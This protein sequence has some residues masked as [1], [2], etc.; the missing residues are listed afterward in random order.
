MNKNVFVLF[1]LALVACG[2]TAPVKE[3]A[4]SANNSVLELVGNWQNASPSGVENIELNLYNDGNYDLSHTKFWVSNIAH[5]QLEVGTFSTS[6]NNITF[7]PTQWSCNTHDPSYTSNFEL[8]NTNL[9][10]YVNLGYV[11]VFDPLPQVQDGMIYSTGCFNESDGGSNFNEM[12]LSN[13]L[14]CSLLNQ[15]CGNN[16]YCCPGMS[17]SSDSGLCF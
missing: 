15:Q 14:N 1:S 17:C 3:K 2:S 10:L 8:T 11:V 9:V 16:S 5:T 12:P 6:G 4:P 13:V 7:F